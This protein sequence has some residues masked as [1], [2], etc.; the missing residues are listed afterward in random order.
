ME[1]HRRRSGQTVNALHNHHIVI[2]LGAL[3]IGPP[4]SP[5]G[6]KTFPYILLALDPCWWGFDG[7]RPFNEIVVPILCQNLCAAAM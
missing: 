7:R 5:L 4:C 6:A 2:A 3:K 1:L